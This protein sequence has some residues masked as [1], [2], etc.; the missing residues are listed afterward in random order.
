MKIF[1]Y[2]LLSNLLFAMVLIGGVKPACFWFL[3]QPKVPKIN[4]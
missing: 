4:S 1:F 2:S 3:Y